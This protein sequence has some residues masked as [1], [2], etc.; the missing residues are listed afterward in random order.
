LGFDAGRRGQGR[1]GGVKGCAVTLGFVMA[2][3]DN[4]VR[5]TVAGASER[6][7]IE[8]MAQFYIY[9][10]SELEPADSPRFSFDA[11]GAFGA[12]PGFDDYWRVEGSHALV[13][14]VGDAPAGFALIN[15]HS[16]RGGTIERNMGEFFVARKYRRGGVGAK[17]V[18]RILS[19]YPGR[20]EVAVAERNAAAK[21]FWPRAIGATPNVSGLVRLE[22]DDEH[23]RGP[24]WTFTAA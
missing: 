22:G 9:D 6:T 15:M 5:V 20:W 7:L 16:H 2:T 11:Q 13:I 19:L 4:A 8:G 12:L 3:H 1:Q 14:R 10:F 17:A 24:I 18:G 21:A 23:W